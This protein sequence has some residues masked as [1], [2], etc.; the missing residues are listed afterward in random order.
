MEATW[1][2]KVAIIAYLFI[3][4][5]WKVLTQVFQSFPLGGEQSRPLSSRCGGRCVLTIAPAFLRH[6]PLWEPGASSLD[7]SM[8]LLTAVSVWFSL[9]VP[10]PL[11][12]PSVLL[13]GVISFFH[14][15]GTRVVI[16]GIGS[17]RWE[18]LKDRCIWF[19]QAMSSHFLVAIYTNAS[20]SC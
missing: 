12:S 7:R 11:R 3:V 15:S 14:G 4:T 16:I 9:T 13:L 2:A 1:V 6:I 18:V 19:K 8:V 20:P 17:P 5:V 10:I